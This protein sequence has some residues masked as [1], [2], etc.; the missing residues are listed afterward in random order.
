MNSLA[1][2]LIDNPRGSLIV[3]LYRIANFASKSRKKNL[4]NNLWAIPIILAYK[5]LT[6]FIFG[7]EIPAATK[8]GRN[9][10]IDHGYSI[11]I[12][13]NSIIGDNCRIK[14]CVTIG[15]KTMEDGGQGG[16]PVIG[17]NVDIG[18]GSCIIGDISIGDNVKI[19]AGAIVV[20]NIPSNSIVVNDYAKFFNRA[21]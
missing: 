16:S 2:Y 21:R 17:N 14:H 11:V 9:L 3:F 6:E 10:F 7:Y 5:F 20:K 19:G 1:L 8:I 15:C 4:A 12:N 13:K 18:A